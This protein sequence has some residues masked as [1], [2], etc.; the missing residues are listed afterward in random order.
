MDTSQTTFQK[1]P[2]DTEFLGMIVFDKSKI[3]SKFELEKAAKE[4]IFLKS[5]LKS[6]IYEVGK[7]IDFISK[8]YDEANKE[9]D[10]R[11]QTIQSNILE[12][13]QETIKSNPTAEFRLE[14]YNIEVIH[15]ISYKIKPNE[16]G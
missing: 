12:Y 1:P 6:F 8:P 13:I 3:E 9:L 14:D 2:L 16:N 15:K 5:K 11:I 4:I 10:T 7:K